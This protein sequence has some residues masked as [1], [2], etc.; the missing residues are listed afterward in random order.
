MGFALLDQGVD[1]WRVCAGA[2]GAGVA[3]GSRPLR[4]AWRFS[5]GPCGGLERALWLSLRPVVRALIVG[6]ERPC[7]V[8]VMNSH[9]FTSSIAFSLSLEFPLNLSP[10]VS[11]VQDPAH[12]IY[13]LPSKFALLAIPPGS[14]LPDP[15]FLKTFTF[16]TTIAF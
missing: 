8:C 6:D 5:P 9:R 12:S 7:P 4:I 2:H 16:P 3:M 13:P 11:P 1:P 10:L 15:T 14:S